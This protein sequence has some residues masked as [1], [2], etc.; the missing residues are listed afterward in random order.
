MQHNAR[1]LRLS[2][3]TENRTGLD[4]ASLHV[5]VSLGK[6]GEDLIFWKSNLLNGISLP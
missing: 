6:F 5:M 3:P 1:Q 4:E 2:T